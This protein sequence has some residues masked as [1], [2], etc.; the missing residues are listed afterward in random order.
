MLEQLQNYFLQ[1]SE[2]NKSC[3]LAVRDHILAYDT[4]ITEAWKYQV[5]F[6]YYQKKML[7]YLNILRHSGQPYPGAV[8][9]K[10]INHP[11][12]LQEDRARVKYLPLDPNGKLPLAVVDLVLRE[13]IIYYQSSANYK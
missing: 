2:P 5:P 12:L 1:L 6:F 9:G 7:C 4:D 11:Q 8:Q 3:M 10:H 13:T